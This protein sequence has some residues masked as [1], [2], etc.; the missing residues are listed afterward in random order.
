MYGL[1]TPES[2]CEGGRESGDYEGNFVS[3]RSRYEWGAGDYSLKVAA[4]EADDVGHWYGLW[5]I[6]GNGKETWIGSLRF[7][8]GA[9][10]I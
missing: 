2:P 4:Q 1:R 9:N 5:V 10:T 7:S 8:P 3:V 6:D